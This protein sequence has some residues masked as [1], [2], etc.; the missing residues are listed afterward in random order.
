MSFRVACALYAVALLILNAAAPARPSGDASRA[1]ALRMKTSTALPLQKRA[2]AFDLPR[3]PGKSP[4]GS[5]AHARLPHPV[6]AGARAPCPVPGRHA[7]GALSSAHCARTVVGTEQ[8]RSAAVTEG[9]GRA[10]SSKQRGARARSA[11]NRRASAG[12]PAK[13]KKEKRGGGSRHDVNDLGLKAY[14]V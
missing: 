4:R 11:P 6:L 12:A 3:D 7:G 9:V 1:A 8:S 13:N 5:N 14:L 2:C 10:A